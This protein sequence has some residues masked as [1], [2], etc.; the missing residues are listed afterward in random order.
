MDLIA[1]IAVI[2]YTNRIL[3][4]R[5]IQIEIYLVSSN[6]HVMVTQKQTAPMSQQ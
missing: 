2:V 6:Q 4:S 3:G 5:G 1:V